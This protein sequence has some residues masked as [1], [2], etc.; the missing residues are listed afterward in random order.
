MSDWSVWNTGATPPGQPESSNS[1][2]SHAD[3]HFF[4]LNPRDPNKFYS[5]TDEQHIIHATAVMLQL[6]FITGLQIRRPTQIMQSVGC[7]ITARHFTRAQQHGTR[8]SAVTGSGVL[9][10]SKLHQLF[11]LSIHTDRYRVLITAERHLAITLARRVLAQR[12]HV[13]LRGLI[14]LAAQIQ[15]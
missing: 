12:A 5:I 1:N 8:L 11:I 7:R 10:T 9:L 4:A 13:V 3:Q 6:S 14:L 15:L 2:F